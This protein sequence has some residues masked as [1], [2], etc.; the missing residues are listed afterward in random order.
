MSISK[1]L[2]RYAEHGENWRKALHR[3]DRMSRYDCKEYRMGMLTVLGD[4]G[5]LTY[6][7]EPI[8]LANMAGALDKELKGEEK[9]DYWTE[10]DI[11]KRG[12]GAVKYQHKECTSCG[13]ELYDSPYEY[14]PRCGLKMLRK[15]KEG[16]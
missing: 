12:Y 8:D 10:Y 9:Y 1:D 3:K 2:I 11:T 4:L 14:C 13:V 5:F 15:E 16:L 7:D 6:E